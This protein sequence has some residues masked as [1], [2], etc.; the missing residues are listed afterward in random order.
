MATFNAN[1]VWS[2]LLL[3]LNHFLMCLFMKIPVLTQ[4]F[5][6][7][8]GPIDASLQIQKHP[9]GP[10]LGAPTT[11]SVSPKRSPGIGSCV[12]CTEA[13]DRVLSLV[14]RHRIDTQN[15]YVVAFGELVEKFVDMAMRMR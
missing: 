1:R 14:L 2:A 7:T 9:N 5:V 12:L 10:K 4:L 11:P 15:V 13:L 6:L 8:G 3:R